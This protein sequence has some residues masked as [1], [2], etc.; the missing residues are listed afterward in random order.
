MS[1]SESQ[2]PRNQ[3]EGAPP[4]E[5]LRLEQAER[6]PGLRFFVKRGATTWYSVGFKT[7]A[8]A[9][10]WINS[11]GDDLDWRVGYL[12]RLRSDARDVQ[13]V[14]RQGTPVRA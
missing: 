4:R 11:H 5:R 3:R 6:A 7:K 2:Q 9:S 13:I 14:S 12:F 8:S 1:E 10:A